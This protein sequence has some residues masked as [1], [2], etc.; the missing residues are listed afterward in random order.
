MMIALVEN[1]RIQLQMRICPTRKS[2]KA[3]IEKPT[4]IDIKPQLNTTNCDLFAL[5]AEDASKSV[6]KRIK[7]HFFLLETLTD[8]YPS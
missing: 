4:R 6:E 8:L 5:A 1:N 2:I 7:Q 3:S